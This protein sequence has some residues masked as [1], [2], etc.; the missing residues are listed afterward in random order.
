MNSQNPQT[1]QTSYTSLDTNTPREISNNLGDMFK[2]S[3]VETKSGNKLTKLR[4][5]LDLA[6][7]VL[8]TVS[9][10]EPYEITKAK[11]QNLLSFLYTGHHL[12]KQY[13][14]VDRKRT[15]TELVTQ[16]FLV[17]ASKEDAYEKAKQVFDAEMSGE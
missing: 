13:G 10:D 17:V 12:E 5:N 2:K 4:S 1:P 6:R 8:K 9:L 14:Y 16:A 7:E 3:K 11:V 15:V